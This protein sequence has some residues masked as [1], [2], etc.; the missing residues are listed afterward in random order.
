VL[1]DSGGIQQEAY[2]LKVPCITLRQNTEWTET[3]QDGW[4]ILAGT[5]KEKIFKL[6]Q[7]FMPIHSYS[8]IF[9]QGACEQISKLLGNKINSAK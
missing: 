8:N 3:I 6:A 9:G 5:D 1:T 7:T 4:N 2:I